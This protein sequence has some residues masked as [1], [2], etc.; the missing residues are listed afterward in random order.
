MSNL[1]SEV[2]R[3]HWTQPV[4]H[5]NSISGWRNP[6]SK[7]W[8]INY[9]NLIYYK[10]QVRLRLE[11]S[12]KCPIH[13][14]GQTSIKKSE[15]ECYKID[16]DGDSIKSGGQ[17][18]ILHTESDRRRQHCLTVS[19]PFLL[20]LHKE[21]QNPRPFRFS[22]HGR[23]L[24]PIGYRHPSFTFHVHTLD[25]YPPRLSRKNNPWVRN[26]SIG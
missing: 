21:C 1:R 8:T 6:E 18:R 23:R 26:L 9:P 10:H 3:I 7:E 25:P 13:I 2:C 17:N 14:S 20:S 15:K 22:Y 5:W 11:D 12:K 16:L 19:D 24:L 4:T